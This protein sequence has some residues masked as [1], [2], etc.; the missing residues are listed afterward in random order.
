MNNSQI[1]ILENNINN[2][3]SNS[4]NIDFLLDAEV[5]KDI[6]KT[7]DLLDSGFLRICNLNNNT[8]TVNEWLKKAILMS[9]KT[10]KNKV[11]SSNISNSIQGQYSWFD[12]VDL[13]SSG[14]SEDEWTKKNY[15]AVPGCFVRHSAFI[16]KEKVA[17]LI[18]SA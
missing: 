1:K 5:K 8:W 7:L 3:W 2:Y 12:K 6:K 10:N 9:F 18:F 15:R 14:W 13:K 17:H 11:F 16:A 4:K